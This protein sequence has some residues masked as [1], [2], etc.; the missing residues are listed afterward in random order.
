MNKKTH[1]NNVA[2]WT[3]AFTAFKKDN[4]SWVNWLNTDH[5]NYSDGDDQIVIY[6]LCS[7]HDGMGFSIQQH[8]NNETEIS[9]FER[10]AG[11]NNEIRHLVVN[12]PMSNEAVIFVS[13]I[14]QLWS[15]NHILQMSCNWG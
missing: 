12:C 6:S 2:Y 7:N 10:K 1:E 3:S 11:A 14:V 4:P 13:N 5:E 9:V 8:V 15:R